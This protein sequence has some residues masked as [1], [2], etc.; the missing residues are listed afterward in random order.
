MPAGERQFMI[1]S[2]LQTILA[3]LIVAL[4]TGLAAGT[5]AETPEG[6]GEGK[7]RKGLSEGRTNPRLA[8]IA[9]ELDLGAGDG[10]IAKGGGGHGGGGGGGG[11]GGGRGGHRGGGGNPSAPAHFKAQADQRKYEKEQAENDA[12]TEREIHEAEGFV[13]GEFPESPPERTGRGSNTGHRTGVRQTQDAVHVPDPA[14]AGG[15]GGVDIPRDINDWRKQTPEQTSRSIRS[16]MDADT[17]FPNDIRGGSNPQ[18]EPTEVHDDE[19]E[20]L[21]DIDTGTLINLIDSSFDSHVKKEE[22]EAEREEERE[23]EAEIIADIIIDSVL[24]EIEQEIEDER[25]DEIAGAAGDVLSAAAQ[26]V[27]QAMDDS[28]VSMSDLVDDPMGAGGKIAEHVNIGPLIQ[29]VVTP[30]ATWDVNLELDKYGKKIDKNVPWPANM[31][32]RALL[33]NFGDE[34]KSDLNGAQTINDLSKLYNKVE[35]TANFVKGV[36]NRYRP[37]HP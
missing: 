36:I 8:V 19:G 4:A 1:P 17:P 7:E 15:G 30:I 28:G 6:P 13:D 3:A 12:Q 16:I 14:E 9:E 5:F 2:C 20:P 11:R 10:L 37:R 31:G 35:G 29:T 22:E 24:D 33:N 23:E 25:R 18:P 21:P 32:A 26:N 34:V 27:R